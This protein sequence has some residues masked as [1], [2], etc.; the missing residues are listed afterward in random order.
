VK[1]IESRIV[2]LEKRNIKPEVRVVFLGHDNEQDNRD[3]LKEAQ[4]RC[5]QDD[6]LIVVIYGDDPGYLAAA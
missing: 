6:V 3:L 4:G 1:G 5:G 2:E